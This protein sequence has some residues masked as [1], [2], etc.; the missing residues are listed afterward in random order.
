MPPGSDGPF[1]RRPRRKRRA[2]K[3]VPDVGPEGA[4]HALWLAAP[5]LALSLRLRSQ[6]SS[7]SED[8]RCS[9]APANPYAYVQAGP[10]VGVPGGGYGGYGGG[11]PG[12]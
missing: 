6:P 8:I 1:C 11:P 10:Q 4:K 2:G 9:P 5:A 3:Q 12:Y 7:G